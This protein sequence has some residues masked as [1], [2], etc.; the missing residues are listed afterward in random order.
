MAE[1]NLRLA[2]ADG[3]TE[4]RLVQ[5]LT[6]AGFEGVVATAA[7]VAVVP[8]ARES[9]DSETETDGMRAAS[10]KAENIAPENGVGLVL[11]GDSEGET[12]F[13]AVHG[14]GSI[15]AAAPNRAR[16][17]E[18][19]YIRRWRIILGLDLLR[20]AVLGQ[21]ESPVDWLPDRSRTTGPD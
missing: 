8:R 18:T 5:N 1:K 19:E 3:V 16:R 6:K 17:R 13:I 10:R 20:R 9:S 21:L 11:C 15:R 4:G 12:V 7:A 14:P 2:V